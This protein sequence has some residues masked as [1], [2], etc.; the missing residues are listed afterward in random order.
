MGLGITDTVSSIALAMV[1]PGNIVRSIAD[2]RHSFWT[3][4]GAASAR[5]YFDVPVLAWLAE[6]LDG[7]TLAGLASRC[8][9]PF[10]LTGLARQGDDVFLRFPA[11]H[12]ACISELTAK[13]PVAANS[14]EYLPGPFEAGLGCFCASLSGLVTSNIPLIDRIAVPSIHA[15]TFFLAQLELRWVSGSS[16]SSSWATLSSARSG[17]NLH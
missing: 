7:A 13:M 4:L 15:K 17:R 2:I 5:A 9:I 16:F 14:S 3:E 11:E 8:I 10:E 12:A 6:P 1:P